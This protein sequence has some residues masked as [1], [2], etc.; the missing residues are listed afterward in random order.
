MRDLLD[1]L[2]RRWRALQPPPA[3]DPFR[4]LE[5]QQRLGRLSDELDA[6]GAD[7]SHP[8]AG[9]FHVRAALMAY[10]R[11]LV[12]ACEIAGVPVPDGDP[13]TARLLAE[14]GLTRAGWSW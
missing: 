8:F 10:D 5:L 2:S 7:R 11:T 12:E 9:G 4:T 3:P 14:V 1:E 13:A 6:L